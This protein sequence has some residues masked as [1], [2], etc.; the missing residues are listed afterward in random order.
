MDGNLA[1]QCRSHPADALS[2]LR[3]V[4]QFLTLAQH[5]AAGVRPK[6][7]ARKFEQRRLTRTVRTENRPMLSRTNRPI[8]GVKNR[9]A[10]GDVGNIA[11]FERGSFFH[12]QSLADESEPKTVGFQ[13]QVRRLPGGK[14][15]CGR[16][17]PE[18]SVRRNSCL[19]QIG[20]AASADH[21]YNHLPA[22]VD[23]RDF[24]RTF[25]ADEGA[26]MVWTES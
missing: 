17:F 7:A 3:E 2:K 24:V 20:R 8:N 4:G 26:F 22:Q 14:A 12:R 15:C 11:K 5:N 18:A 25:T 10:V 13:P 6:I 21:L 19:L 23:H 9:L 16:V 1:R